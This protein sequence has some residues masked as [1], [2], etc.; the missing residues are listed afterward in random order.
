MLGDDIKKLRN[1]MKFSVRVLAAKSGVS[2]TTIS[3]ME[4]GIVTNP[5]LDTIE[6]IT[7]AFG[8]EADIQLSFSSN[9]GWVLASLYA[10]ETMTGVK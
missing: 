8:T 5:T 1:E 7:R 3:E 4:N 2:K 9:R 10:V 6:K